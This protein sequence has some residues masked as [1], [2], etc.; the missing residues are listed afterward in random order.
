[1]L[2]KDLATEKEVQTKSL[3]EAQE[4]LENV[5]AV[6][7]RHTSLEQ[8]AIDKDGVLTVGN[9]RWPYTPHFMEAL[10]HRIKMP[11]SYALNI[12]FD[13][14]KENFDRRKQHV[15]AGVVVCIVRGTAVNLCRENYFPARTID[16][17]KE[18]PKR[19]KQLELQE[20]LLGD[21]GVEISWVDREIEIK[22][23]PSDVIFG[24]FRIS[25]SEIGI[26]GLKASAYTFRQVCSNGAVFAD[27]RGVIRWSHDRRVTYATN[28]ERFCTALN[29]LEIPKSELSKK[30]MD[31]LERPITDRG[32]INLWRRLRRAISAEQADSIVGISEKER[33]QLSAQLRQ[34]EDPVIARL[35]SLNTYQVHNNITA[36]AKQYDLTTRRL[37]EE[38]GGNFLWRLPLN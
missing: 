2:P 11:L 24:G 9:E 27:E 4:F 32:V 20:L 22:V 16:V 30:Y 31:S 33:K 13:L 18:L 17:I 34:R 15:C 36:T 28:I 38:I 21:R 6:S 29:I 1:M 5:F 10:A 25:N 7:Y 3:E 8:I 19:I 37:L 12:D 23:S 35:T 26:R 14:F